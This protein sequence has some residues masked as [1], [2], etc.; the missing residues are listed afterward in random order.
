MTGRDWGMTAGKKL[1]FE[2]I[3]RNYKTIELAPS[4]MSKYVLHLAH[5]TE[6]KH[7]KDPSKRQRTQRKLNKRFD[8]VWSM[9]L[10]QQVLADDSLD[11]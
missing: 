11:K 2:L 7:I 6:P 9:K 3:D 10:I 4:V 1:Y 8:K 5:A